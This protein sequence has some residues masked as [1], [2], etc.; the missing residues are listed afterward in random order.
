MLVVGRAPCLTA[1]T[2]TTWSCQL[3]GRPTARTTLPTNP[4]LH[5][6]TG[7][8]S[9]ETSAL[10]PGQ[11]GQRGR[12]WRGW[13]AGTLRP[14]DLTAP[15]LLLTFVNSLLDVAAYGPSRCCPDRAPVAFACG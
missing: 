14:H 9:T 10:L 1:Q 13:A 5:D 8:A 7:P 2:A 4:R 11:A 6:M 15:L 3:T 12:S